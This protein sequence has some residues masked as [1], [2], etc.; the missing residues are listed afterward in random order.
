MSAQGPNWTQ[1]WKSERHA[2]DDVMRLA[3]GYFANQFYKSFDISGNTFVFDYGCGPG[4]LADE[5][6]PKGLSFSGTDINSYFIDRCKANHPNG[7]FFCISAD[8]KN[9]GP[10]LQQNL[11]RPADFIILLSITQYLSSPDDLEQI[12]ASLKPHL[13]ASGKVIIADVVDEDTRSYRDAL[14]LLAYTIKKKRWA[15]S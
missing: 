7:N 4:F 12:V 3:T 13:S 11:S 6:I 8:P 15:L 1:F 10:V 14:A 9:N 2:F 5:L